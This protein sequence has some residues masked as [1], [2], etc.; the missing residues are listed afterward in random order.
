M[1][2]ERKNINLFRDCAEAHDRYH[3][4]KKEYDDLREQVDALTCKHTMRQGLYVA[5]YDET[6]TSATDWEAI[7]S[8]LNISAKEAKARFTIKTP[9]TRFKGIYKEG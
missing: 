2:K 8:A 7:G 6:S 5:R 1:T 4:A 9:S 3:V